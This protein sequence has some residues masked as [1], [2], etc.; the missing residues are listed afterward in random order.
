MFFLKQCVWPCL[1]STHR[2][3]LGG[4]MERALNW[5]SGDLSSF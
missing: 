1:E 3:W 4:I 2:E 5:N